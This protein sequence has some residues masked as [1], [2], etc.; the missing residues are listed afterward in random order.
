[1]DDQRNRVLIDDWLNDAFLRIPTDTMQLILER[2]GKHKT[3]A[4]TL[5]MFYIYKTKKEKSRQIWANEHYCCKGLDWGKFKFRNADKVLR[6]LNLI[7]KIPHTNEKTGKIEKWYVWVDYHFNFNPKENQSP[8]K[9]ASGN[10]T[11]NFPA[12]GNNQRVGNST[13]NIIKD[14]TKFKNTKRERESTQPKQ[15]APVISGKADKTLSLDEFLKTF[16]ETYPKRNGVHQHKRDAEKKL[17]AIK[18]DDRKKLLEAVKIYRYSND[19]KEGVISHAK[20]WLLDWDS[21]QPAKTEKKAIT[22]K[23]PQQNDPEETGAAAED[24]KEKRIE[25]QKRYEKMTDDKKARIKAKVLAR[26]ETENNFEFNRIRKN[27]NIFESINAQI[28]GAQILEEL[29]PQTERGY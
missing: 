24:I 18:P 21:W 28:V 17:K 8:K 22:N 7:K 1:M 12:G 23:N 14:S 16:W 6:D 3:D 26:L 9:R 27:E 10:Q 25:F 20:N 5:Y 29:T 4:L 11:P 19:V 15:A 13:P 2:G